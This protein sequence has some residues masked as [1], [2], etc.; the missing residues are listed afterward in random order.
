MKNPIMRI[1]IYVLVVIG[2]M[3]MISPFVWM[4]MTSFKLDGEVESW[5]PKWV[6]QSFSSHRDIKLSL[7]RSGGVTIDFSALT[8]E[9]F[10]NLNKI[11]EA[12]TSTQSPLVYSVNDDSPYRGVMTVDFAADGE[13]V[14]YCKTVTPEE[15]D[16]LNAL[17][18]TNQ[19]LSEDIYET[20]SNMMM[21]E[22][23]MTMI[24]TLMNFL[25]FEHDSPLTRM[26][27]VKDV[28]EVTEKISSF[29]QKNGDKLKNH[30]TFNMTDE[31]DA[32][33]QI[34]KEQ[35]QAYTKGLVDSVE[36]KLGK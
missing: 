11:I 28:Q 8:I 13:T 23:P 25:Y 35:K 5:P 32:Q 3:L 36:T 24:N 10:F 2:V 29:I 17:F 21:I 27:L 1:V 12:Q 22:D 16:Q 33:T 31:D 19:P 6:S 30:R 26:V 15:L 14:D 9:E 4:I 18:E 20:Y 7:V 34:E